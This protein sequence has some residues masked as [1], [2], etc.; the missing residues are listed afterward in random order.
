MGAHTHHAKRHVWVHLTEHGRLGFYPTAGDNVL[1]R[2]VVKSLVLLQ[3]PYLNGF[4]SF[5]FSSNNRIT[6][7]EYTTKSTFLHGLLSKWLSEVTPR[8]FHILLSLVK[9]GIFFSVCLSVR[10]SVWDAFF[11]FCARNSSYSFHHT[12]IKPIPS[13]SW[14]SGACHRGSVFPIGL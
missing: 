2:D 14:V 4:F 9:K 12:Q 11:S 3:D 13:K 8:G 7:R 6:H 1:G 5:N 10:L